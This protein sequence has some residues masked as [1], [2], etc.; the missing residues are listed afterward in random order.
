MPAAMV[1]G[2]G[3][4]LLVMTAKYASQETI[5]KLKYNF[6][7]H[8]CDVVEYTVVVATAAVTMTCAWN[9]QWGQGGG[10]SPSRTRTCSLLSAVMVAAIS[11]ITAAPK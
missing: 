5:K 10:H 11:C 8:D 3:G 7:F 4:V 9:V 1:N 6:K 2:G